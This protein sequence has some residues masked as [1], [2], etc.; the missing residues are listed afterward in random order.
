MNRLGEE[1]D[2]QWQR[3]QKGYTGDTLELEKVIDELEIKKTFTDKLE[4]LLTREQRE[5]V[6]DPAIH[7]VY[8]V[9]IHSPMLLLNGRARTV[10]KGSREEI[11]KSVVKLWSDQWGLDAAQ[12]EAHGAVFDAWLAAVDSRLAPVPARLTEWF[13]YD[14]AMAA[15]RAQAKVLRELIAAPGLDEAVKGKITGDAILVVPRLIAKE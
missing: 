1:Y 2:F 4:A 5:A 11:R 8:I 9:D 14:D 6:I 12:V 13:N 15:G 10:A 7:H 3:L